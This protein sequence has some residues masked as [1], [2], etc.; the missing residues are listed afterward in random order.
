MG[1]PRS[2]PALTS[3]ILQFRKYAKI[4]KIKYNKAE[5]H[6]V[7]EKTYYYL[8][9]HITASQKSFE[10]VILLLQVKL[11]QVQDQ[12]SLILF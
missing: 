8:H 4:P 5:N 3:M 2:F 1:A 10:L 11:C 9:F 7:E 12:Q 6:T